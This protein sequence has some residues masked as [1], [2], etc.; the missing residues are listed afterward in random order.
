MPLVRFRLIAVALLLLAGPLRLRAQLVSPGELSS[1]HAKLEGVK[2]CTS[3]HNFGNKTFRDQCLACHA[4]IR[5]RIDAKNGYHFTSRGIACDICHKEHHGRD[6][7][8]IRWDPKKFEHKQAGFALEGKH[9]SADCRACHA[10]ANIR[11]KDIAGRSDAAKGRTYLGLTGQCA[12]CHPD[13]HRGQVSQE[14]GKCHAPNAWKPAVN[15]SHNQARFRLVGKHAEVACGKCH[16][17][18]SDGRKLYDQTSY[19]QFTGIKAGQCSE[20]HKDHHNGSFGPAC[21][22]C[23]TPAGWRTVT[24]A[25]EGFNHNATKYPLKGKH[26]SVA[27]EKCHTGGEW[28]RFAKKD[29]SRC[30]AC[31]ADYHEGQFAAREDKGECS[32]CHTLEGFSPTTYE[33]NE[34]RKARF[35]LAGAHLAV[36]C[37]KCHAPAALNG[38]RTVRFSWKSFA[39]VECHADPHAGQFRDRVDKEGCESCHT[40]QSWSE[41]RFDH[42]RA[43]FPLE[44][45]HLRLRC[46]QCHRRESI[47][48]VAA[49][50][51]HFPTIECSS[52]HKD[53]HD[54][55]FTVAATGENPCGKCHTVFFWKPSKFSHNEQSSFALTGKHAQIDCGKCH[56]DERKSDGT[57]LRRYKPLDG[58]CISCH[59]GM[60]Q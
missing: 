36:P 49:T 37:G 4:E 35:A 56:A 26:Q 44:G 29:V 15:F 22:K 50:R 17:S 23:H 1:P 42:M 53:P 33:L 16:P 48:G 55:Q 7:K 28:T 52:C 10:P 18:K 51:Y 30:L 2:N 24:M 19:L 54:A 31:H 11:M 14:C 20:C 21:D 38:K 9:A 34:H 59:K 40:L 32:S 6:F 39:C 41:L 3:C 8:L 47:E 27:C 45:K 57:L 5:A 43:R 46:D 12:S 60:K 25:R 13:M 58:R